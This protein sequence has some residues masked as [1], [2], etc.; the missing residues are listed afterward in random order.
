[1]PEAAPK[2][3]QPANLPH[4]LM[5]LGY[6]VFANHLQHHPPGARLL[7]VKSSAKKTDELHAPVD[8]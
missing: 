7:I 6:T 3:H 1:M 4:G 5:A 2:M 8:R